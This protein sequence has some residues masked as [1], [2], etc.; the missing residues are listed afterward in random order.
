MG[1]S[2]VWGRISGSVT[3]AMPTRKDARRWRKS[4]RRLI[5]RL[6]GLPDRLGGSLDLAMILA[7][8][9]WRSRREYR[10]WESLKEARLGRAAARGLDGAE[11]RDAARADDEAPARAQ[12]PRERP[13]RL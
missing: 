9:A 13:V 3:Q 6:R 5:A 8:L 7:L 10:T 12:P 2:E 1:A 4:S 11:G